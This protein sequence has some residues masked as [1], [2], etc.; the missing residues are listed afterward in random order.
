MVIRRTSPAKR[1]RGGLAGYQ[2]RGNTKWADARKAELD[3]LAEYNTFKDMGLGDLQPQGYK[4]INVRMIYAVKHDLRH[5][6][7]LVAGG[8]LTDPTEDNNYSGVVS[9]R[10][11]RILIT[12]AEL[13]GMT[14]K[15]ADVGN[16]YLEA[17]TREKVY[18]VV[19]DGFGELSGHTLIIEKALYGL[20]SSGARFH[21][22][23]ADTLRDMGYT[24]CKADPEDVWLKDY[25]WTF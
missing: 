14:T 21:E 2:E 19:G 10:S 18:V 17:Y 4:K 23:F 11:L 15:V 1:P 6:A 3:Q 13:N 9:L 22:K 12:V 20:R 24:P 7:R 16:A 5:K 8:H 25:V